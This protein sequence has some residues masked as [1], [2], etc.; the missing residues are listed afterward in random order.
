MGNHAGNA[1]GGS[2]SGS[3]LLAPT[4]A[5]GRRR[6]L[7][8]GWGWVV[9]L[10]S[11]LTHFLLDG[12]TYAFGVYTPDIVDYYGVSR[13]RVGWVNSILVGVTFGSGKSVALHRQLNNPSRSDCEQAV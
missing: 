5:E 12:V 4:K 10:G 3:P 2:H 8:G 9:V 1:H 6:A 7:D 11:F 13:Q